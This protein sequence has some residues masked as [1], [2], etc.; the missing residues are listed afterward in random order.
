MKLFV[1]GFMGAGKSGIGREAARRA[2]VRFVDTDREV[3][4]A[5]GETV[6]E[7][8][9]GQGEAAFRRMERDV[10][11]TV[12]ATEG[13][14]IVATGGGLPCEGDAMR[15]MNEMGHTVYLKL[16][17]GKLM[18][19]LRHGQA[20]R[21]KLEGMDEAQLAQYIERTLP[22][23]EGCYMQASMIID[24]DTLSDDSVT[25]YVAGYAARCMR[26]P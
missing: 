3:E 1:V 18:H 2:G 14:M 5:C 13:D 21:P 26:R 12:A 6:G 7:I 23:R 16:S 10:L 20:R 9:A 4:A 24:C 25:E 22:E 19:R 11:E 15:F 8:F 17:S